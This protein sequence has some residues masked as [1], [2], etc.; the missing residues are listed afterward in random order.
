MLSVTWLWFPAA[1]P[2]HCRRAGKIIPVCLRLWPD[3]RDQSATPSLTGENSRQKY[4]RNQFGVSGNL[5]IG[6]QRA[7]E[8]Q[9]TLPLA[10]RH[11]DKLVRKPVGSICGN[12]FVFQYMGHRRN[13][14]SFELQSRDL[15]QSVK[16]TAIAIN[17]PG[18]LEALR[19]K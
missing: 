6:H 18:N 13:L 11:R 15:P 14:V 10:Q 12:A 2:T 19:C 8:E 4:V 7:A 5:G 17:Q 1:V 16:L 3:R 9:A